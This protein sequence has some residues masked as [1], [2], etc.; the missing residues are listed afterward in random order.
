MAFKFSFSIVNFIAGYQNLGFKLPS[1][2]LGKV[3]AELWS[4]G[5]SHSVALRGLHLT[6]FHYRDYVTHPAAAMSAYTAAHR[7]PIRSLF[8]PFR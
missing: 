1:Y 3:R 7:I 4:A 8:H 6:P 2:L 5:Q